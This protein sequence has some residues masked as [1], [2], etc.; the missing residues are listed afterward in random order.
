MWPQMQTYL[1]FTTPGF[2]AR[3]NYAPIHQKECYV[4]DVSEVICVALRCYFNGVILQW[5]SSLDISFRYVITIYVALKIITFSFISGF[6]IC[7]VVQLTLKLANISVI[8]P[9][10]RARFSANSISRNWF[11]I[12]FSFSINKILHK[13]QL[14]HIK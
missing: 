8:V 10:V 2:F 7:D 14:G 1:V 11:K 9:K 12:Q 5:F 3:E 4:F 6:S 13:H